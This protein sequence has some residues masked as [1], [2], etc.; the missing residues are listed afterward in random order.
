MLPALRS[1]IGGAE[2]PRA[3][4]GFREEAVSLV[5]ANFVVIGGVAIPGEAAADGRR[6]DELCDAIAMDVGAK[7]RCYRNGT[8]ARTNGLD[9]VFA[10]T[11]ERDPEEYARARSPSSR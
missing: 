2:L 9:L 4:P 1:A 11:D 7:T 10:L 5:R 6:V 3:F 8:D